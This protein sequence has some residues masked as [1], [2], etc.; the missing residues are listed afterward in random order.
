MT[1]RTWVARFVVDNGRVTEEGG[2]LRT[3]QR[4]RLDESDVDLHIIC[5]PIGA[6]GE[7]LGAQALDAIGRSFLADRLSVTGGMMRALVN[8]HQTLLDWNRRSLPGDQV[9]CGVSA[10]AVSGALVYLAQAGPG[11][12]LLHKNGVLRS[13][14]PAEEAV[15]PLGEGE[16]EPSIRR[17]DIEPG[18][19][20]IAASPALDRIVDRATLLALIERGSDEALPELYLLTR[21]LPNFALFAVTCT[22]EQD[23]LP[24]EEPEEA[25]VYAD[26]LYSDPYADTPAFDEPIQPRQPLAEIASL[27]DLSERSA[28]EPARPE[29]KES[30]LLTTPPL[31]I[32]RPVIKL[33][34]DQSIGRSAY[35]RTTGSP[36]PFRLNLVDG[37][38]LRF[39]VAAVLILLV[40]GFVPG[41]VKQGRSE[42]LGD[43]VEASQNEL[44]GA[45]TA[46]NPGDKRRLLEDSRRLATEAL[47]L[48]DSNTLAA[49]LRD[50]A[51]AAI[52]GLDGVFDLGA[53]TTVAGLSRQVTGEIS[54]ESMVVA[55]TTA[56]VLDTKGGRVVSVPIGG[57]APTV[58]F[59][60]G[61]TYGGTPAKK[62]IFM[63]WES[64]QNN[65]LLI[66]DSERKLF[67]LRAGSSPAPL[68]LRRSNT[69]GSVGGIAAYDGNLYVLD[70]K[71]NQ[72]Y[73]Y[74]PAAAGFDS[75]PSSVLTGTRDLS[76][77]QGLAVDTD[78]YVYMK[79]GRIK[80]YRTGVEGDFPLSGIDRPIKSPTDLAIVPSADE[81]YISDSAGKRIV[82]A[83]KDGNFKRQLVSNSLTDL[84]ALAVDSTGSQLYVIT[85][86]T[87]LTAPVIRQNAA[88]PSSTPVPVT[89]PKP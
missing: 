14:E 23:A 39:G 6:K 84:R 65:R 82:V 70:P 78:I 66:M 18:D 80:R 69:W 45:T 12:A 59:Q 38:L 72:I 61:E 31:D 20:L 57:S 83:S 34:S 68:A 63:T 29:P 87:V 64:G 48:D 41:L 32:S 71:G 21:D 2:R 60:D 19:L 1:L 16:T 50:Q 8:T 56:F 58:A 9:T 76:T 24:P 15:E 55:D 73:R 46:T 11:L 49:Q 10:I 88:P 62:P 42:K 79:D 77:A 25:E 37:K 53:M 51:A 40:V 47:R 22:D 30:V 28:F 89:T 36:R 52:K 75:E 7:E 4:R 44:A 74:L 35:V 26:P 43:L 27:D 85:S 13:L 17:L 54:L 81:I 67:E 33:R 3:F 86:D 5:E